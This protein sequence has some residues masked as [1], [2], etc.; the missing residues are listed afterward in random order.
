[1]HQAKYILLQNKVSFAKDNQFQIISRH[2][3][4]KK[5][6][7]IARIVIIALPITNL[8]ENINNQIIEIQML[9]ELKRNLQEGILD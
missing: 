7:V 6:L 4:E 2:G 9:S 8:N 1:M 5:L 3:I